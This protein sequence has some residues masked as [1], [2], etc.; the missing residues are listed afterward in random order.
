MS[1]FQEALYYHVGSCRAQYQHTYDLYDRY[2]TA[3]PYERVAREDAAHAFADLLG[4]KIKFDVSDDHARGQKIMRAAV[5]MF[6][7][8]ELYRIMRQVHEAGFAEAEQ[9][10]LKNKSK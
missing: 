9:Q 6:T 3:F 7:E 2:D 4:R 8:D 10:A 5:W 1:K